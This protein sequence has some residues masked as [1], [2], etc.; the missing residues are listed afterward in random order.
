MNTS[1]YTDRLIDII[2]RMTEDEQRALLSELENRQI[3]WARK[4]IR[5]ERLIT[6]NFA[7]KGR[8]YQNFIQDISLEG[9][10]IE[11]KEPFEVGEDLLLTIAYHKEQRPFKIEGTVVRNPPN[12]I[13]VK[14]KKVSQVQ[15]EIIRAI[16]DKT[17]KPQR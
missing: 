14:F 10:F 17:E 4:Y 11:T 12:G 2:S 3:K 8:A 1:H 15:E 13:G 6:V 7:A 9:V 16:I 5:E